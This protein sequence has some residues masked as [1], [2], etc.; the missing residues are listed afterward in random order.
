ML[1]GK[2]T[3]ARGQRQHVWRCWQCWPRRTPRGRPHR[4][5]RGPP[6]LPRAA[7]GPSLGPT[8]Q[9]FCAARPAARLG[10]RQSW[11]GLRERAPWKNQKSS[12]SWGEALGCIPCCLG[13]SSDGY[14]QTS[15][16]A[17]IR[18]VLTPCSQQPGGGVHP[19]SGWQLPPPQTLSFNK[20]S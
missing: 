17:E 10:R 5:T 2:H 7:S 18:D 11:G 4:M 16:R 13:S 19:E 1:K 8:P 14:R 15:K 12:L 9:R 6:Q 3:S 20:P